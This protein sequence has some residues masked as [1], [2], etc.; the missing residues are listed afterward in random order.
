MTGGDYGRIRHTFWTDPDI[1]RA[2]TPEQKTLLLYYFTSPHRTLI[3]LYY[4]PMEYAASETGIPVERVRE[5]TLGALARFVTYDE[6]TEE[7]FVHRAGRHQV[8]EQLS[9][10]DNQRKAVEKALTEA[11]SQ[12]LVRRFLELYAHWPL[13]FETAPAPEPP[14][15]GV[16]RGSEAKAV[17]VAVAV[18]SHSN[19]TAVA[20]APAATADDGW[21]IHRA[22]CEAFVREAGY[23]P[24]ELNI[25][26]GEDKAIWQTPDGTQAPWDDRLRLLRLADA[27]L[28][29]NGTKARDLR[30]ALKYVKLQQLDP[31]PDRTAAEIT[32]N[33]PAPGSEA[34]RVLA[35]AR[36]RDSGAYRV[37][38][39][40]AATGPQLVK[41]D[42]EQIGRADRE[43]RARRI[44]TLPADV[45]ERLRVAARRQAGAQAS[46]DAYVDGVFQSLALAEAAKREPPRASA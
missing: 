11:H 14:S 19:P 29:A 38:Q 37:H 30:Q 8:G 20:P 31:I 39:P 35:S 43:E 45:L 1:K 44:A 4:C 10:K 40:H 12:T 33:R 26:R 24:A 7:I 23:G 17:A 28:K 13:T 36:D 42:P 25:A 27:H 6:Q 5:W 3:G 9:A 21:Q 34:E 32:A 2:L 41:A 18:P 16:E 22:A 46:D 15:K